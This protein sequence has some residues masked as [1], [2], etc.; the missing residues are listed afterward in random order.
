MAARRTD[1]T[2]L[3]A[4]FGWLFL[5]MLSC[6]SASPS[7]VRTRETA[8]KAHSVMMWG[9]IRKERHLSILMMV[10]RYEYGLNW[11]MV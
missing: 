6:Q 8:Q 11:S 5:G 9:A 4:I 3:G 1:F 7:P 2:S 10:Y